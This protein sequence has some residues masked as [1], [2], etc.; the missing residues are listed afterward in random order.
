[1]TSTTMAR[2]GFGIVTERDAAGR[3][4]GD[5]VERVVRVPNYRTPVA[6]GPPRDERPRSPCFASTPRAA[7][8]AAAPA[9]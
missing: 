5:A 4:D 9:G 3:R 7:S 6:P 1:M 8:S 2:H